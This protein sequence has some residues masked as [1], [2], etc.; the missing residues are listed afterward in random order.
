[1]HSGGTVQDSPYVSFN[2]GGKSSK[3]GGKEGEK[4][5]RI[6]LFFFRKFFL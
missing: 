5:G 6:F 1:M 3:R 4:G 2:K